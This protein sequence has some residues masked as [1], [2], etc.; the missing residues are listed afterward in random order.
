ME[1]RFLYM[2]VVSLRL[3]TLSSIIIPLRLQRKLGLTEYD[4]LS[5]SFICSK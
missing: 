5:S 3:T 4:V 1:K 2:S